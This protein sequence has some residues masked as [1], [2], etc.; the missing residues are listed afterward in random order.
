MGKLRHGATKR[1]TAGDAQHDAARSRTAG[2]HRVG[3]ASHGGGRGYQWPRPHRGASEMRMYRA[4]AGLAGTCPRR[5]GSVGGGGWRPV[6]AGGGRRYPEHP[7]IPGLAHPSQP[8]ASLSS[9]AR[10]LPF[11]LRPHPQRWVLA[12]GGCGCS[13][14]SPSRGL[15]KDCGRVESIAAPGCSLRPRAEPCCS[16]RSALGM[17]TFCFGT[18]GLHGCCSGVCSLLSWGYFCAGEVKSGA[19]S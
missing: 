7:S 3:V 5:V 11:S 12:G 1:G 16:C 18:A 10:P 6:R 19:F 4:C 15:G 8:R 13:I 17:L 2:R 14:L 9:P